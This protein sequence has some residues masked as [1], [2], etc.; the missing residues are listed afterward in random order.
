MPFLPIALFAWSAAAAGCTP[1]AAERITARHLAA[2]AP[3][4]AGLPADLVLGYSP[5][6][7][8]K[9]VFHAFE[10]RQLAKRHNL[11]LEREAEVCFEFPMRQLTSDLA[12][13]AMRAA[14][15]TAGTRIEIIELSRSP[16]PEGDLEFP[17]SGLGSISLSS[18]SNLLWRGHVRYWRNRRFALWAKVKIRQDR[19]RVVAAEALRPGRAVDP[20]QVRLVATESFSREA[21][22]DSI[23]N[24]IGRLPRRSIPAGAVLTPQMLTPKP[25]VA[26]GD[27][28][29]VEVHSGAAR[30]EVAVRAEA[31]G[32][33]GQ[34]IA[35]K[36]LSTGKTFR[37]QIAGAG[38]GIVIAGARP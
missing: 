17:V 1:V 33:A 30:L 28:L 32:Q 34:T 2:A 38:K 36:N 7:G 10:L 13:G 19:M 4:F 23:E 22:L 16:V 5:A 3:Q 14:L 11:S 6:P 18:E 35:V 27:Q 24:A 8:V 20:S 31:A 9:R 29:Q 12:L 26:R 37:A 25:D 21:A 15:G